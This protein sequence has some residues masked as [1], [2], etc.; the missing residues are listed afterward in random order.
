MQ[1]FEALAQILSRLE[2]QGARAA[3][4]GGLAVSAWTEPRFTRDVAHRGYHRGRNL[5]DLLDA[6]IG[7][8]RSRTPQPQRL[9]AW[10]HFDPRRPVQPSG[11]LRRQSSAN[12]GNSSTRFAIA[13]S[14]GAF[15]ANHGRFGRQRVITL[16]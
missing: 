11:R 15:V 7:W 13:A 9:H 12:T 16:T 4:L 1:L 2:A 5:L 8:T 14:F 6:Y 3:V 10:A